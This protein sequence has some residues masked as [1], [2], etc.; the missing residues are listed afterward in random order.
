M[1]S[2][3]ETRKAM[4]ESFTTRLRP[5]LITEVKHLAVNLKKPANHVIE[6]AIE[7][8]LKEYQSKR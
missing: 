4:R 1:K 2:K 6:E 7:K 8:I 5:E 3:K